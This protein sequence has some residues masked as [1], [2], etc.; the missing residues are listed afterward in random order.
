M[1][2]KL[3]NIAEAAE[4]LGVSL[5]TLRRWDKNGKLV[6]I[7]KE[8]GVH[9]YY[10]QSDLD[11]FASDL[12]K[13]AREWTTE[14][15]E[16]PSMFYCENSAVFQTRLVKMQ[17]AM[18]GSG[19]SENI[20][21]LVVAVAGEVGNNSFDHNLGKWPDIPGVFFGYD[22]SKRQVVLADRGLGILSTLS[23]VRPELKTHVDALRVAFTEIVSGR[24]PEE[25]GNGLKF[26]RRVIFEN[27][28]SLFFRSG[29]AE[30]RLKKDNNELFI[31]RSQ[32][33][34]RGCFTIIE[35]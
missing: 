11:L 17:N 23:R 9:R 32:S 7:R 20:L 19:L 30:L 8:G 28:I 16:L 6:A 4:I 25:R 10:R 18:A 34:T 14:G 12:I 2:E 1:E 26:V 31:T 29:D 27:P 15:S 33:V 35:Y 3:L 5:D 13:I 24:A 22:I 21:P